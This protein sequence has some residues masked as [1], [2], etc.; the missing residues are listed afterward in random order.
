MNY[1]PHSFGIVAV[2]TT[3]PNY[4]DQIPANKTRNDPTVSPQLASHAG[5]SKTSTINVFLSTIIT[6]VTQL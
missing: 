4:H 5:L 2:I 6:S 3:Q 1:Y